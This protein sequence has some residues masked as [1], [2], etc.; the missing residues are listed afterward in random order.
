MI[1]KILPARPTTTTTSEANADG[2]L[3]EDALVGILFEG[4]AL[5]EERADA[6]AEEVR[7]AFARAGSAPPVARAR[8]IE[9]L[10]V[11]S[12]S[13]ARALGAG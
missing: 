5:P 4:L 6:L 2:V 3:E 1:A 9:P 8:A 11:A 12:G 7:K 10:P 13:L